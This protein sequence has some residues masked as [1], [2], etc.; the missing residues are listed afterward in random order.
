VTKAPLGFSKKP[1]AS[2][3]TK[4]GKTLTAKYAYVPSPASA[5]VKY[6]W[7]RNGKAISKATKVT[8]KIT[9]TDRGKAISVK[10][11]INAWGYYGISATSKRS[12]KIKR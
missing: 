2:G 11:S 8:Y 4:V 10:V 3:T 1:S 7:Y 5:T 9:K 12:N 6:Q